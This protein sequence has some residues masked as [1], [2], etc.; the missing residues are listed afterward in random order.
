MT[1]LSFHEMLGRLRRAEGQSRSAKTLEAFGWLMLIEA[2]VILFAPHF[3]ASV[4]HMPPLGQQG[5]NFFRL[6]GLLVGGAGHALCSERTPQRS[7]IRLCLTAGS[8]S[9][10]SRNGSAL[11][12]G[13]RSGATRFGLLDTGRRQFLVDVGYLESRVASRRSGVMCTRACTRPS[14]GRRARCLRSARLRRVDLVF[15]LC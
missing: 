14:A 15:P 1:T 2:P 10:A 13:H 5:A 6:M 12:P 7:R 11:V 3:V 8:T 4:L 9:C